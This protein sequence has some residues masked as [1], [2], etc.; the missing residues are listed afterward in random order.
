MSSKSK[1]SKEKN[2][3]KKAAAKIY[4]K[5][6]HYTIYGT[7]ALILVITVIMTTQQRSHD[8]RSRADD[9]SKTNFQLT[10]EENNSASDCYTQGDYHSRKWVGELAPLD[11]FTIY[12]PFCEGAD[13]KN[14]GVSVSI[15]EN[16]NVSFTMVSPQGQVFY[17]G[18]SQSNLTLCLP[19]MSEKILTNGVWKI[20]LA[21]WK[22]VKVSTE[23]AVIVAP[24]NSDWLQ[25]TCQ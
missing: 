1:K 19:D 11:T 14:V 17:P 4:K 15:P 10:A 7:M 12:M 3:D 16:P 9:T 6:L 13:L 5:L 25:S 20:N 24:Q 2:S 18:V 8:T 22:D 21:N 23:L